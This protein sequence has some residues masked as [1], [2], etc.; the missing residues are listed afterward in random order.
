MENQFNPTN[1]EPWAAGEREER[2]SSGGHYTPM[3]AVEIP[4]GME[5]ADDV[6][7]HHGFINH[8]RVSV[9]LFHLFGA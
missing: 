7:R 9:I 2:S 6:A 1:A 3:W 8:G 5:V 4:G